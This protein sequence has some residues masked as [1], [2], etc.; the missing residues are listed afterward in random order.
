MKC[1]VDDCKKHAQ[2]TLNCSLCNKEYCTLHRL[3]EEHKCV[4]LELYNN[5]NKN[6]NEINLLYNR[7]SVT[8]INKID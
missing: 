2:I 7:T 4:N 6:Q 1:P 5:I 8:K 3:P